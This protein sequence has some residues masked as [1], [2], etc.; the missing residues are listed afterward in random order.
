MLHQ[1]QV[2]PDRQQRAQRHATGDDQEVLGLEVVQDLPARCAQRATDAD[3]ARALAHPEIG[4]P[5][6]AKRGHEQ[7]PQRRRD[8]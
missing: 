1:Q 7:Q 2:E 6:G 5:R 8:Q 3:A 4:Q